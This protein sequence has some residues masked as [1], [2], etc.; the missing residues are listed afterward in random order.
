GLITATFLTLVILPVFYIFF[1]TRSFRP[2][3]KRKSAKALTLVLFLI[4]SSSGFSKTNAQE[5]KVFDLKQAIQMA[6]DSNLSVRS[7]VY[8]VDVQKTLKGA[9]WN[10]PK[11]SV[12]GQYGQFNSYSKDNSFTVSQ[13]FSFPT[14]YMNQSKLASANVKGSELKLMSSRLEIATLVKQIYR[15][16]AYLQSK[17][18]LFVWQDSLYTGFLR[19]AE[20]R[21]KVGETNRLEL[22]SARSQSMET[23]NQVQQINADLV[24]W[25]QKLQT[26][27]NTGSAILPADSV[28]VRFDF[29]PT[30]D[31]AS[32]LQNPSVMH[33]QQQIEVSHLESK[34]EQSQLLPDLSIGYY[35]Q[36]ILG[37]QEVNGVPR[38]FGPNDRFSGIQVGVSIPLFFG[39][40]AANI[41]AAKIKEKVTQVNS[42]NYIKSV[43]GTYRSLLGDFAKYAKSL[44]YY[45]KQAIPEADAIIDQSTKSYRAGAMDYLDYI[46]NLSRTLSI[47]LN[48]LDALNSYNQT[49]INIEYITGKTF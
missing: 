23:K 38:T 6:L 46:Q 17:R 39:S 15:E 2:T 25:I 3:F 12:E 19:A 36:T 37:S 16:F 35:N 26:L 24:N 45:E 49:I 21:M 43:S 42:E 20:L 11:T 48:Y 9:A 1:S 22:I 8:A 30:V 32:L 7:S 41:K 44:D 33:E 47:K 28:L 4:M 29:V 31:D 18:K 13:S 10:I 34:V 27:L 40:Y 5:V 14:L